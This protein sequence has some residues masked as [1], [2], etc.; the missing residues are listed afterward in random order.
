MASGGR[1]REGDEERGRE[2]EGEGGRE[3]GSLFKQSLNQSN[4]EEGT[5]NGPANHCYR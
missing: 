3:R 5:S 1:E 4:A 2:T